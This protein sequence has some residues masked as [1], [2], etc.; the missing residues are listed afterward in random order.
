ML[1]YQRV[2]T[3][4]WI[5]GINKLRS[6][7]SLRGAADSMALQDRNG[8]ILPLFLG[9]EPY[10][11]GKMNGTAHLRINHPNMGINY[12]KLTELPLKQVQDLDGHG[13]IPDKT[14]IGL[15]VISCLMTM[16]FVIFGTWYPH[17]PIVIKHIFIV[18][19]HGWLENTLFID[20]FL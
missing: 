5:S 4:V 11:A 12:D 9:M 15:K 19:T 16:S 3:M 1:V 6:I 14:Q 2:I 7:H 10:E 13:S 8:L 17:I 20:H 18:T